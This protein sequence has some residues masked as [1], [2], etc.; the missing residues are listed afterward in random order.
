M[1]P[2]DE[3][4]LPLVLPCPGGF[5]GP[6]FP[7]E[8]H[9]PAFILGILEGCIIVFQ[10]NL[11]EDALAAPTAWLEKRKRGVLSLKAELQRHTTAAEASNLNQVHP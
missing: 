10:H 6:P 9:I 7:T 4:D 2:L 11:G 1:E 3:V 5:D 8:R